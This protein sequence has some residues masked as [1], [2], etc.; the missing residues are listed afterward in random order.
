MRGSEVTGSIIRF[1]CRVKR[2]NFP[3]NSTPFTKAMSG[4]RQHPLLRHRRLS[5]WAALIAMFALLAWGVE[6]A[7]HL[8]VSHETQAVAHGVHFCDICAAFQ[9]G[10]S[11]SAVAQSIPKLQP[12][13]ER[14]ITSKPCQQPQL[15]LSYRSRAPP[16]A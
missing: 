15:V 7:G 10:V 3:R 14:E 4:D 8:H 2:A 16:H 5:N 6:F 12:A 11:G 13:R 1:A 9:A